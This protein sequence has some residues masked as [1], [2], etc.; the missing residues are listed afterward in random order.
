MAFNKLHGE[1]K[2]S[3]EGMFP[4][5]HSAPDKCFDSAQY[6]IRPLLMGTSHSA[7]TVG[8]SNSLYMALPKGLEAL[9]R[10]ST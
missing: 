3:S 1:L 10:T 6:L 8:Y 2:H 9:V 4:R 5:V 7:P